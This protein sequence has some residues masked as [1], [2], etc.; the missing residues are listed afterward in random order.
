MTNEELI[1]VTGAT[2]FLG[3]RLV[4]ELLE[5]H[6]DAVLALLIRD[7]V[8]QSG[9]QRADAIVPQPS[10][11]VSRSIPETSASPTAGWTPPPGAGFPQRRRA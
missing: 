4:Q 10:G 8:G 11:H 1:L 5:R 6:P 9:E 7:K 2:G 3:M